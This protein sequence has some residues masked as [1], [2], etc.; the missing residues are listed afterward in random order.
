MFTT[1]QEFSQPSLAAR[2][3]VFPHP[4][5]I[6]AMLMRDNTRGSLICGY[7]IVHAKP[8]TR[9]FTVSSK[10]KPIKL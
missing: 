1:I 9:E 10:E 3:I 6:K 8:S 2:A 5:T 4:G 7:N